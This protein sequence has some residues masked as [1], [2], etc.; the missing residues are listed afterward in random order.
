MLRRGGLVAFPT[1]TVYG[2]GADATNAA[3]VLRIYEA[4][5]RDRSDPLIVHV[6][7]ARDLEG[8]SGPVGRIEALLVE[9]FW[10]GALTLVVPRGAALAVEVSGGGE[11]VAVRAPSH[12]VA[13]ALI[14]AAGVPVA[15]PSANRF[16]R[17]SATT[18]GHVLEDLGGRIE[19]VL[20]AGPSDAGIESTVVRVEDGEVV[21][22][23]RAGAVTVERI[24]AVLTPAGV[25]VVVGSAAAQA[26]GSPGLLS[27]HYAPRSPLVL[28]H[29]AEALV[30]EV[31]RRAA[32]GERVGVLCSAEDARALRG[33]EGIVVADLGPGADLPGVTRRLFAGMRELD[34]AGVDVIV[35]RYVEEA[36]LGQAI[37]DRLRRAAASG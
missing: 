13:R 9:A 33:R 29:T 14:A 21:R 23:L 17:T 2:L 37:N 32:R 3:A 12:P 25:P 8:I 36:G 19:M 26:T 18:A 34:G 22:V 30:A 16:M 6:L 27:R 11:T 31:G 7:G 28:L 4:K 24:V 15:A 5:E 10:P 1:E 35:A 20:D